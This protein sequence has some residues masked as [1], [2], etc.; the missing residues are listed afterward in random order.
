MCLAKPY[1][2]VYEEW[3]VGLSRLLGDGNRRCMRQPITGSNNK[4]VK[5]VVGIKEQLLVVAFKW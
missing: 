4:V 3:V 1:G 5:R 2:T